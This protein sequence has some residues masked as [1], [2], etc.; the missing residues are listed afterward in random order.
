MTQLYIILSVAGWIWTGCFFLFLTVNFLTNKFVRQRESRG[1]EVV[2][3]D[4]K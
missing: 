2:I 1:F 3:Q 4:E